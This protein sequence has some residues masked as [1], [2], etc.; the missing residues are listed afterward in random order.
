MPFLGTL[1][2]P[3][4]DFQIGVNCIGSGSPVTLIGQGQRNEVPVFVYPAN[5]PLNF[6]SRAVFHYSVLLL[7]W[8]DL[9]KLV[10][11]SPEQTGLMAL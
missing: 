10:R 11:D 2:I 5:K 3:S 1:E 4:D 8:S 7:S 6:Q 9:S